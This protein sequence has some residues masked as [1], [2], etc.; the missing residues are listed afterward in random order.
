M[1]IFSIPYYFLIDKN[2]NLSIKGESMK[3]SEKDLMKLL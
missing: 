2:G 3:V 1:G